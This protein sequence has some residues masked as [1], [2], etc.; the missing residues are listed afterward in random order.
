VTIKKQEECLGTPTGYGQHIDGERKMR[1]NIQVMKGLKEGSKADE[2]MQH[3]HQM[4]IWVLTRAP[5]KGRHY[6]PS[7]NMKKEWLMSQPIGFQPKA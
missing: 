3:G 5:M 2:K 7:Y 6:R 4:E 1:L